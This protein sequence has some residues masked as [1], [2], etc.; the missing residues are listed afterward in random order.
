MEAEVSIGNKAKAKRTKHALWKNDAVGRIL[1][2]L[3]SGNWLIE[4]AF[5]VEMRGMRGEAWLP[6]E[7]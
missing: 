7:I 1:S 4:F 6:E 2:S 3:N 5:E